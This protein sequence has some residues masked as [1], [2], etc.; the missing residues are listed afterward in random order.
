MASLCA[1]AQE[2]AATSGATFLYLPTTIHEDN[3]K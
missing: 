1:A 3:K 2:D